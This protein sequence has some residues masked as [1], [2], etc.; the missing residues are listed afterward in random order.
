M[1][2]GGRQFATFFLDSVDEAKFKGVH[3]FHYA[4]SRFAKQLGES[5]SRATILISSRISEWNPESDL[6]EV[7]SKLPPRSKPKSFSDQQE[8]DSKSQD[9]LIVVIQP[10]SNDQVKAFCL[11]LGLGN[12]D[13]FTAALTKEHAWEFARRPIDVIDLITLWKERGRLGSLTEILES[14]L[15]HG[16]RESSERERLDPLTP[17]RA[18]NGAETLGASNI[19]CKE[20][21]FSIGDGATLSVADS[22][23]PRSCLPTDWS[24][25]EVRALMTRP[26]F[27]GASYGTIRFHHRRLTE[28]LAASWF[29][30]LMDRG[31]ELESLISVLFD[32]RGKEPILR[33]ELEPVTAWMCGHKTPWA[34][35]L[36]DIVLKTNPWSFFKYGDP[37]SLPLDYRAKVI[38]AVVEN[39]KD[40]ENVLIDLDLETLSRFGDPAF[41]RDLIKYIADR[42]TP[43]DLRSD[44]LM[45]AS[46]SGLTSC[47]PTCLEIVKDDS[48][49]ESVKCT[50]L[51][52]IRKLADRSSLDSLSAIISSQTKLTSR[53]STYV[54]QALFP[55][56]LD[57]D[58]LVAILEKTESVRKHSVDLPYFLQIHVK[59]S[60]K[61]EEAEGLFWALYKL[62]GSSPHINVGGKEL[63]IS[64]KFYWI[65]D[66]IVLPMIKLLQREGLSDKTLDALA[67][68]VLM[69]LEFRSY[70]QS[71]KDIPEEFDSSLSS[72]MS[73][74]QRCYWKLVEEGKSGAQGLQYYWWVGVLGAHDE[75]HPTIRDLDWMVQDSRLRK[76]EHERA[77]ILRHA[78][79]VCFARGS[80]MSW[81][82]RYFRLVGW[83]KEGIREVIRY[84]SGGS[85]G[86]YTFSGTRML[87]IEN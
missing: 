20:I 3:E 22:I 59:E 47:V 82:A 44:L 63:S 60:M 76:N 64:S 74:R 86:N 34:E 70:I 81:L 68:G 13:D 56:P 32:R 25:L 58:G 77:M 85:N 29:A 10:L 65:G 35:I 55:Y 16:L 40:R 51:F 79:Q 1:D 33:P 49:S 39:F 41:E 72:N 48:Q 42:T 2:E 54:C 46:E 28:F 18:R 12:I 26:V 67:E 14:T 11:H 71:I 4:F 19:L 23:D 83:D 8:E 36:R 52:L 73:V 84:I 50:A 21:R 17:L 62:W 75:L 27:D 30:R 31:C 87:D 24:M 6:N 80:R 7:L 61:D 9:H 43:D 66:I 45:I 57:A 53:L 38:K 78:V 69:V 15:E 37:N 5:I